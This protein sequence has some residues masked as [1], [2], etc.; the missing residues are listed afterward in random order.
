MTLQK[1][2]EGIY[3][4]DTVAD[5][6]KDLDSVIFDC[7]GVLIDVTNSYDITIQR[8]TGYILKEIANITKFDPVTSKMIEGFKATG[9]FNDEVD[10][11]YAA[12]LSV[13]A[14]KSMNKRANEFV[15]EVI[16]NADQTGIKSV[17][18]YLDRLMVDISDIRKKLN[19][20][21]LHSDNLIH[22]IFDQIFYGPE[23]YDRLFHKKSNFT[24]A[25]LIENDVVLVK[26]DML[27]ILKKK[28]QSKLAI[29]SG[30]GIESIR[31][32]LN[33]LLKEFDVKNS[34]FLEDEPRELAKPNPQS[35]AR[36]ILGLGSSHCLYV[37][38][39]TEDYIM[40][41]KATAMNNI[42]TFCVIFG[43]GKFPDQKRKFFE[44]KNVAMI[45]ES[46][47]LLPKALNLV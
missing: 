43:T 36:S 37:G 22:S 10:L 1:M 21:G 29:V 19:Y 45:L 24:E 27:D 32:S 16:L 25:G 26:K 35:L 13:V 14:A 42:T 2:G 28:F 7:D 41:Q 23:L 33:E 20:P 11:T 39:S 34:V 46:I 4:E 31:H 18:K 5:E 17:E 15:F 9:G 3:V 38:D 6:L 40:A 44:E 12:I 8:T 47:D 30:R